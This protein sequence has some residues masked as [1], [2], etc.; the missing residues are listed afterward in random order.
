MS[1]TGAL[2]A[3]A[4][5]RLLS[6]PVRREIVD[7]LA[8]SR[9][10]DAG[11]SAAQLAELLDLHVTTVRF[12]LDQLVAAQILNVESRR[13]PGA[14]RPTKVYSVAPGRLDLGD[15]GVAHRALLELLAEAFASANAGTVLTPEQAGRRWA[16]HRMGAVEPSAPA[17]SAGAWLAKVGRMLDQLGDWGYSPEVATVNQGRTAEI[18]LHDCPFLELAHTNPQVVCGV[19]RGLIAG[20]M[21][22]LGEDDLAVSLQPFTGPTTCLARV[23]TRTPFRRVAPPPPKEGPTS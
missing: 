1:A 8:D 10:E 15:T 14:G 18:T 6:S 2:D 7:A 19:H 22:R 21:Q 4:G 20:S 3:A 12:H 9:L 17:G 11:M 13:G 5:A 16:E 23:T